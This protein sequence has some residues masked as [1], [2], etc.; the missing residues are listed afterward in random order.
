[1]DSK[2]PILIIS[3]LQ[4]PFENAK[5]LDFCI[6][7]KRHFN[8]PL[9]NVLN[10]GDETDCYHGGNWPKNPD[11]TLSAHGELAIARDKLKQWGAA[12]PLM[13]I[14]I[15]NHGL[16]WVRKAAAAEIPSQMLLAY[17]KIFEMPE[18]WKW[19][20]EWRFKD[21][22]YPFRLIHGMG[23]SGKDGARNAAMDSK[24]ST[25]IGHLH[26]HA[27]VS[28]VHNRGMDQ[29]IFGFNVGSLIDKEAYAFEYEKQNRIEPCL[30]A[31][32]IFNEGKTPVWMPLE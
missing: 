19:Q 12:F 26:A 23:Y 13:K 30:G 22:K 10:V 8:I 7:L 17:E 20:Y 16:R 15:S 2:R 1:M 32:V 3:D 21:L 11:G 9:E 18:G 4:I 31:G 14:A 25:V 6:Y 5:A 24:M 29:R 28:H 27:G